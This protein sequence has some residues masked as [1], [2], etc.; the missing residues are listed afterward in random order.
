MWWKIF[1][2]FSL[3][4]TF[5]RNKKKKFEFKRLRMNAEG[6][7]REFLLLLLLLLLLY[8][9]VKS[10]RRFALLFPVSRFALCRK[11]NNVLL[12]SL[13]VRVSYFYALMWCLH[14]QFNLFFYTFTV[15]LL[16]TVC[17]H[18]LEF[19][20]QHESSFL[21][22]SLSRFSSH[23]KIY[24]SYVRECE[25]CWGWKCMRKYVKTL[26]ISL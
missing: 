19:N 5:Q 26:G 8:I 15:V 13:L 9:W 4:F 11:G 23:R 3:F 20:F 2:F 25:N 17:T 12:S 10:S 24:I 14:K 7:M 16:A 21:F 22:S 1:F 18:N 6:R